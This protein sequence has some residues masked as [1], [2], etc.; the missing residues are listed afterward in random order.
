MLRT[1]SWVLGCSIVSCGSGRSAS[2]RSM[3]AGVPRRS[4]P[5]PAPTPTPATTPTAATTPTPV[6]ASAI[7]AAPATAEATQIAEACRGVS[8]DLAK[9]ERARTCTVYSRDHGPPRLAVASFCRSSAARWNQP[10][11]GRRGRRVV[12]VSSAAIAAAV[13]QRAG[14]VDGHTRVQCNFGDPG[15]RRGRGSRSR[16]RSRTSASTFRVV[17]ASTSLDGERTVSRRTG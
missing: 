10:M 1:L 13:H 8:L 17:L 15:A 11:A 6:A 4:Q 5:E 3:I 7:D 16:S 9:L 12:V 14:P 2:P